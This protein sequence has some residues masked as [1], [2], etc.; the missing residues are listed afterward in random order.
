MR[1]QLPKLLSFGDALDIA[2]TVKAQ[3]DDKFDEA[4]C[5]VAYQTTSRWRQGLNA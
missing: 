5:R 1:L 3:V 4:S 2:L